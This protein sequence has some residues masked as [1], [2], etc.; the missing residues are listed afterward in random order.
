M[1]CCHSTAHRASHRNHHLVENRYD[2]RPHGVNADGDHQFD[3]GWRVF[4]DGAED[5]G[6]EGGRDEDEAHSRVV[7]S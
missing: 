2:Q 4:H 1:E 3:P 6:D 5:V 7:P